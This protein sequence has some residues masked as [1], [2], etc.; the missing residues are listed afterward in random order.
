MTSS[1]EAIAR[2]IQD[3]RI[4][5]IRTDL[6][7]PMFEEYVWDLTEPCKQVVDATAYYKSMAGGPAIAVYE[8]H[9]CIAPPFKSA[10]VAYQNE[11]GNVNAMVVEATP[12]D[13]SHHWKSETNDIDW[14]EARWVLTTFSFLG[15][16]SRLNGSPVP[17]SGPFIMWEYAIGQQGQPL[18]LHWNWLMKGDEAG[19]KKTG[20]DTAQLVLLGTLN[21]LNCRNIELVEPRRPRAEARKL[22]RTGITV[23]EVNVFPTGKSVRGPGG[24]RVGGQ[25][26]T[27]V[28]GHFAEYG[29]QYGKGKLFGKLEGRFWIPQY[30]RGER[31][32]GEIEHTYKVRP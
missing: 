5:N 29:E 27:S 16:W 18:D 25:P 17:T 19:H 4:G 12:A 21:F 28:R 9:P 22:Q 15:G 23:R 30:A 3:L 2:V 11:H 31:E 8:D 10:V 14:N 13:E 20:W 1:A 26:L 6:V 7:S 24:E 32:A